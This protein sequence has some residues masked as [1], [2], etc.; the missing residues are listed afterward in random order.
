MIEAGRVR[1][2][3]A[4]VERALR[5]YIERL[6]VKLVGSGEAVARIDLGGGFQVDLVQGSGHVTL[7]LQL[8]GDFEEAVGTYENRGLV[9]A[10]GSDANGIYAE[11]KD[12]DGHS[13]RF[14]PAT[15]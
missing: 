10:R 8:R 6:G 14:E 9:F 12:L 1:V 4:D 3:V 15:I 2:P 13:L 5:F 11:C 7:G